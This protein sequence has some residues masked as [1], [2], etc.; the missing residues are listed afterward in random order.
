MAGTQQFTADL[1]VQGLVQCDRQ[2]IHPGY[3]T[4]VGQRFAIQREV[5][6]YPLPAVAQRQRG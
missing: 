1:V 3:F 2:C 5:F 6:R 4:A